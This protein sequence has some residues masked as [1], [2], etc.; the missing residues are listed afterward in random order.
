M[1]ELD[2]LLVPLR[3]SIAFVWI[4]AGVVSLGLYPVDAS[5]ALLAPLGLS[6]TPAYAA[7]Y[8]GAALDL[9]LGVATLVLPHR[10]WLW[11]LQAAVILAYTAIITWFLPEQWLHPFGAVVKN[12]PIL[13]AIYVLHHAE[14]R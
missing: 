7:L 2:R 6:G 1:A 10:R 14:P 12:V 11:R 8:A 9:A 3:F 4:A 5:L 13:A